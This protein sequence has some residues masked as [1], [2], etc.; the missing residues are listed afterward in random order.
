MIE[1][2]SSSRHAGQLYKCQNCLTAYTCQSNLARHQR[3]CRRPCN[4]VAERN[5]AFAESLTDPLAVTNTAATVTTIT[6]ASAISTAPTAATAS[7][8][9]APMSP[10]RAALTSAQIITPPS[11]PTPPPA[12]QTAAVGRPQGRRSDK[13]RKPPP[14]P[15]ADPWLPPKLTPVAPPAAAPS[16]SQIFAP[17]MPTLPPA[18]APVP[19]SVAGMPATRNL[20]LLTDL[21]AAEPKIPTA[22]SSTQSPSATSPTA[23][24]AARHLMMWA[25]MSA[26]PVTRSTPPPNVVLPTPP[27]LPQT[28]PVTSSYGVFQPPFLGTMTNHHNPYQAPFMSTMTTIPSAPIMSLPPFFPPSRGVHRAPT[29]NPRNPGFQGSLPVPTQGASHNQEYYNGEHRITQERNSAAAAQN[30][31]D[32]TRYMVNW[33]ASQGAQDHPRPNRQPAAAADDVVLMNLDTGNLV[34]DQQPN[35]RHTCDQCPFGAMDE[36]SLRMHYV[37]DHYDLD[38]VRDAIKKRYT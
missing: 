18:V 35:Y 24:S 13:R 9:A 3:S 27:M 6:A 19:P 5:E 7:A 1:F 36:M 31:S 11:V 17:P 20:T 15:L 4:S 26:P 10:L 12:P 29:P 28:V 38:S 22:T 34:R 32:R 21:S 33:R 16:T 8:P 30:D 23:V 2:L 37:Q 25:D 14:P